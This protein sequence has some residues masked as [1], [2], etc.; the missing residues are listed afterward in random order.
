MGGGAS[1]IQCQWRRPEEMSDRSAWHQ[2]HFES[3]GH[4][5]V[6]TWGGQG[7]IFLPARRG[8]VLQSGSCIKSLQTATDQ[9]TLTDEMKRSVPTDRILGGVLESDKYSDN[10]FFRIFSL[11]NDMYCIINGQKMVGFASAF[12]LPVERQYYVLRTG[13]A[14][15]QDTPASIGH[16]RLFHTRTTGQICLQTSHILCHHHLNMVHL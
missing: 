10:N 16:M 6:W 1:V 15:L 7:S 8:P 2:P 13:I 11:D 9:S 4:F 5:G 14:C 12:Q 3:L